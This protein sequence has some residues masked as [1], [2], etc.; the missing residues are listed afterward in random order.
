MP[1]RRRRTSG[2]LT[3][4]DLAPVLRELRKANAIVTKAFPGEPED[5][6]PVHTVYGGAHLF[7]SDSAQKL[8][9][10]ALAAL[11][12]Y[13][14]DAR[15]LHEAL[16]FDTSD[17]DPEPFAAT[18]RSR[19]VEKLRREPVEDFRIDFEDGY[20]NRP[21]A[22]EDGQA[23][24]AAEEVAAGAAAGTLPPFIGIRIKP[25]SNELHARSL[26]TLDLFVTTLAGAMRRRLPA[27]FIVTVPKIMLAGQVAAVAL[28]CTALERRLGL[29][30]GAIRL[31]LMIETPQS[32]FAPDGSSALRALV[33]A[34]AGRVS[35]AHF[36]TYDYTALCGITAAWQ[37]MR[38]DVCDFAKHMMQVALA[39][40]GVKLSDGAT[41]IMPVAPHRAAPGQALTATQ[42]QENQEAVHRAWK[43]HFDDARHSLVNGFYQGWDL[44]P[45]Q[46]PTRYAAVYAFFL[47]ARP[48]ATARLGNFVDK[49]AQATLV[50]DVFDDA[51]TGQGLLNFFARGLSAGALTLAEARETGL[52]PEELHGRSFL[53]ILENRR[54]R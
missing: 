36:G 52:T 17:G 6:Q 49:A 46:L 30:A 28:A 18:V 11:D 29:K 54:G 23:A 15:T 51:A 3:R 22:E 5:R 35:G 44:H 20:G 42:K 16:R 13:A 9:A 41:N 48:A 10:V 21:D 33:A 14:Q 39:Q 1:S 2:S 25:M 4:G 34:G 40:S 19:V 53:K 45:A 7:R 32:I 24:S 43:I 26:R 38:H 47:S 37:H 12:E 31:E 8:G 50:G 27:N